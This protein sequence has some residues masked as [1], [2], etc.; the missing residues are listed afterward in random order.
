MVWLR[1]LLEWVGLNLCALGRHRK[2]YQK[3]SKPQG[4][5]LEEYRF[6]ERYRCMR[7]GLIG[8]IDSRCNLDP[9]I[10]A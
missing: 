8:R 6:H 2:P 7:R 5:M 10:F 3:E 9:A 1:S 4:F